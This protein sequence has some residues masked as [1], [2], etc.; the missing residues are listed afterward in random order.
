[1]LLLWFLPLCCSCSD[2]P[3]SISLVLHTISPS[4]P[5]FAPFF[6][7]PLPL[8]PPPSLFPLPGPM[9]HVVFFAPPPPFPL[10]PPVEDTNTLLAPFASTSS[11]TVK[12]HLPPLLPTPRYAS[13][14]SARL[15]GECSTQPHRF[16]AGNNVCY[17]QTKIT[18][19]IME[20]LACHKT[21]TLWL[22]HYIPV[23]P[24]LLRGLWWLCGAAA[25]PTFV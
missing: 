1:M 10:P 18:L 23:N 8:H 7:S 6:L 19:K 11:C 20:V 14:S 25:I 17:E 12:S 3:P 5:P 4:D 13:I 2:A 9:P 24:A 22:F 16:T 21:I 15:F